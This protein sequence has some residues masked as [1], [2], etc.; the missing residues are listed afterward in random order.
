MSKRL[1]RIVALLL[2]PCLICDPRIAQASWVASNNAA[3]S[4]FSLVFQTQAVTEPILSFLKTFDKLHTIARNMAARPAVREL[5]K[6][7]QSSKFLKAHNNQTWK[8]WFWRI[9]GIGWM[10]AW[11]PAAHTVMEVLATG[12]TPDPV[13]FAYYLGLGTA[14]YLTGRYLSRTGRLTLSTFQSPL[15]ALLV[16]AAPLAFSLILGHE[17]YNA[18]AAG[19]GLP[20]LTLPHQN[21]QLS[22]QDLLASKR[23]LVFSD[24]ADAID[25]AVLKEARARKQ[26]YLRVTIRNQRDLDRLMT[27]LK[28]PYGGLA[29]ELIPGPLL[30]LIDSGGILLIDYNASDPKLVEIFNS[31]SDKRP[32]FGSHKV[33]PDHLT[34]I[35]VMKSADV[36]R[37]PVSFYSRF[38]HIVSME[39]PWAD[40]IAQ[41]KSI[42]PFK[43]SEGVSTADGGTTFL[44]PKDGFHRPVPEDPMEHIGKVGAEM[45]KLYGSP[46]FYQLL[47]GDLHL[48]KDGWISRGLGGS[49]FWAISRNQPLII[50]G[51]PWDNP[52]FIHFIR[53]MLLTGEVDI[54]GERL[55]LPEGF[56]IYRQDV[57]YSSGINQK[58]ILL[59]GEG[60]SEL[61]LTIVNRGT[62]DT[63]FAET[64][65]VDGLLLAHDGALRK[66]SNGGRIRITEAVDD[67]VW[68][69]IMHER[70]PIDVEVAPGVYIPEAY[71]SLRSDSLK[72]AIPEVKKETLAQAA[73]NKSMLVETNDPAFALER[74]SETFAGRHL[75]HY[76][77]T[78]ETSLTD[79]VAS[80]EVSGLNEGI[81]RAQVERKGILEALIKGDVVILEGLESNKDLARQLETAL[82]ETPYLFQYKEGAELN[83]LPGTLVVVAKVGPDLKV[84]AAH[85]TEIMA[86]DQTTAAILARE[87]PSKFR[88]E[89]YDKLLRLRKAIETIP[90][91]DQPGLYPPRPDFS[92]DRLRLLYR[93]DNWLEAFE[94][95]FI[96]LYADDPEKAAF[97][98]TQVRIAFDV[99]EPGRQPNSFV[100]HKLD[101]ALNSLIPHE[102]P[103]KHIWELTDAMSLDGL[104]KITIHQNFSHLDERP[105]RREVDRALIKGARGER[106]AFYRLRSG[107]TGDVSDAADIDMESRVGEPTWQEQVRTILRAFAITPVVMLKGLPGTGK[108]FI[109]S[110]IAPQLGFRENEVFGPITVGSDVKEADVVAR[111]ILKEGHTQLW[112]ETIA[113]WARHSEGG[114]LVVDEAN[115]ANPAFWNFMEGRFAAEPH[116]WI[117][118]QRVPLSQRHQILFTG[119]QESV[120][121]RK[122]QELIQRHA[123]T[124]HFSPFS[125]AF[126]RERINDDLGTQVAHREELKTLV[127]DLHRLFERMGTEITFSLRDVQELVARLNILIGPH[128]TLDQVVGTAWDLYQGNFDPEQRQALKHLINEKYGVVMA[129]WE[130]KR[131][132]EIRRV[133][134]PFFSEGQITLV[135]ATA[136]MVAAFDDLMTLREA[137]ISGQTILQG[138]RGMILEG[139]SG[140]GKDDPLELA[141]QARGLISDLDAPPGTPPHK[142]FYHRTARIDNNE[143]LLQVIDKAK[144]DGSLVI[145]SEANI[146]P[147][148]FMEGKLNDALTGN[149]APGF[150]FMMTV[151]S[152][153][154]SGRDKFS[155]ALL[156]RVIYRREQDYSEKELLEIVSDQARQLLSSGRISEEDVRHAVRAHLWIGETSAIPSLRPTPRELIR[157]V[158]LWQ[159]EQRTLTLSRAEELLIQ[160]YGP[161]YLDQVLKGQPLPDRTWLLRDFKPRSAVNNER[162]LERHA[163]ALV[164]S[165]KPARARLHGAYSKDGRSLKRAGAYQSGLDNSYTLSANAFEQGT[166][167][168]YILHE[169]G[170]GRRTRDLHAIQ[171][172]RELDPLYQDLEDLRQLNGLAA[173]LPASQMNTPA[174]DHLRFAQMVRTLN[175]DDLL[176]WMHTDEERL[177][178]RQMFA[179]LLVTHAKGLVTHEEADVFSEMV[180]ELLPM[181]PFQAALPFLQSAVEI[182]GAFSSVDL[183]E[184]H[185]FQQ[186]RMLTRLQTMRQAYTDIP[187]VTDLPPAPPAEEQQ[188][189]IRAAAEELKHMDL[190]PRAAAAAA[191]KPPPSRALSKEE[192]TAKKEALKKAIAESRKATRAE[193]LAELEQMEA[194]LDWSGGLLMERVNEINEAL[195]QERDQ[196][197][198]LLKMRQLNDPEIN[199][200]YKQM[201]E[202]LHKLKFEGNRKPSSSLGGIFDRLD[203]LLGSGHESGGGGLFKRSRK[204][205]GPRRHGARAHDANMT[206]DIVSADLVPRGIERSDLVL[207]AHE[208]VPR[209]DRMAAISRS[210]SRTLDAALADFVQ[211]QLLTDKVYG[212][213]GVLEIQKLLETRDPAVSHLRSGGRYEERKKEIVLMG[214]GKERDTS[215]NPMAQEILQH[216]LSLGFSFTVYTTSTHHYADGIRTLGNLKEAAGYGWSDEYN[217]REEI[218]KNLAERHKPKDSYIITSIQDLQAR[219]EA[220][221][222][223]GAFKSV[224]SGKKVEKPSQDADADMQFQ[225]DV[226]TVR[227]WLKARKL[228]DDDVHLRIN[229]EERSI[230]MDLYV[231]LQDPISGFE[232]LAGVKSLQGIKLY[233]DTNMDWHGVG[234]LKQITRLEIG[235][236]V[237]EHNFPRT[238]RAMLKL[239]WAELDNL[240]TLQ[241]A[242]CLIPIPF[243]LA[244]MPKLRRIEFGPPYDES[245]PASQLF[246]AEIFRILP[247]P[248]LIN[249]VPEDSPEPWTAARFSD[250]L[251]GSHLTEYGVGKEVTWLENMS[252]G[253]FWLRN[254]DTREGIVS[255]LEGRSEMD[256]ATLGVFPPL[257][258]A[259]YIDLTKSN[260]TDLTSLLRHENVR[261]IY[262]SE[263]Q[264]MKM[265]AEAITDFLWAHSN[266]EI[267]IDVISKAG[268]RIHR[269][270]M[271]DLAPDYRPTW[272][273]EAEPAE[274]PSRKGQA[275]VEAQLRQIRAILRAN[276][277]PE[278]SAEKGGDGISLSLLNGDV[279]FDLGVFREFPAL[280]YLDCDAA[281]ITDIASLTTLRQLKSLEIHNVTQSNLDFLSVLFPHLQSLHVAGAELQS[282]EPL[283]KAQ[284]LKTIGFSRTRLPSLAPLL[285]I[286]KLQKVSMDEYG[287]GPTDPFYVRDY[288]EVTDD[289]IL[290]FMRRHPN[291]HNLKF[292]VAGGR[293]I[294]LNADELAFDEQVRSVKI[295]L[296]RLNLPQKRLTV[297]DKKQW[298]ALDLH[299]A[300]NVKDF[301]ILKRFTR[302]AHLNIAG[303]NLSLLP[304]ATLPS[305]SMVVTD[306]GPDN[307]YIHFWA[308]FLNLKHLETIILISQNE[309]VLNG[310]AVFLRTNHVNRTRLRIMNER[311]LQ[312]FGQFDHEPGESQ[313][314][315][316]TPEQQEMAIRLFMKNRKIKHF[317]LHRNLS[318]IVLAIEGNSNFG[319]RELEQLAALHLTNLKEL[320]LQRTGIHSIEPIAK[321]TGLDK[322]DIS[323]TD[324]QSLEPVSGLIQLLEINISNTRISDLTPLENLPDLR[325]IWAR[326]IPSIR[327]IPLS[328][329]PRLQRLKLEGSGIGESHL[330]RLINERSTSQDL[331]VTFPSGKTTVYEPD[332][333]KESPA[334]E[335]TFEEQWQTTLHIV[336]TLGL[337]AARKKR[338]SLAS[339]GLIDLNLSG[340]QNLH[341]LD[342][343]EGLTELGALQLRNVNSIDITGLARFPRLHTLDLAGATTVLTDAGIQRLLAHH[344][345][346]ND[347]EITDTQGIRWR[348]SKELGVHK[349]QDESKTDGPGE[350]TLEQQKQ[351]IK[352][353]LNDH[354]IPK[355]YSLGFDGVED[356][357]VLNLWLPKDKLKVLDD[358]AALPL[359]RLHTFYLQTDGLQ[360]LPDFAKFIHLKKLI[361]TNNKS[362]VDV[363]A[364]QGLTLLEMLNLSHTSVSDL[365]PLRRLPHLS[366]LLI[367]YSRVTDFQPLENIVS[368][369]TLYA[370][371]LPRIEN[372]PLDRMPHLANLVLAESI[373]SQTWLD[374]TLK[375]LNLS[376]PLYVVDPDGTRRT[377]QP[378]T[379]QSPTAELTFEEQTDKAA[380][381]LKEMGLSPMRMYVDVA[382]K[383]FILNFAPDEG[384]FKDRATSISI[385]LERL[386]GMTNLDCLLL[387]GSNVKH[388]PFLKSLINLKELHLWDVPISDIQ[389]FA[390][391]PLLEDLQFYI[392]D[393]KMEE[394][395]RLFAAHPNHLNLKVMTNGKQFSWSDVPPEYRIPPL[396]KTYEE[397][398]EAAKQ[399]LTDL[400]LGMENLIQDEKRQLFALDLRMAPQS[401]FFSATLDVIKTFTRMAH[402]NI[403]N[404]SFPLE[405]LENLPYLSLLIYGY[406]TAKFTNLEKIPNL[407]IFGTNGNI[408]QYRDYL[409]EHHP[410]GCSI[411]VIAAEEAMKVFGIFGDFN[412]DI[413]IPG[414]S[415]T[416]ESAS[417]IF[418]DEFHIFSMKKTMGIADISNGDAAF[419]K[420]LLTSLVNPQTTLPAVRKRFEE[421]GQGPAFET[422]IHQV[423]PDMARYLKQPAQTSAPHHP[424]SDQ[425]ATG[426]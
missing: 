387:E 185:Q 41:I 22:I 92:L 260:V 256:D 318:A 128:W 121:G 54:Y 283:K 195:T 192:L 421:D 230:F 352:K 426:A 320:H 29:H 82:C 343:L 340:A 293:L 43:Q 114:L 73:E 3:K 347:L 216:L 268:S 60:T 241:I 259:D 317:E 365:R 288:A 50:T 257:S 155:T 126:L 164:R 39:L 402:L 265:G 341:N 391:L 264:Y 345:N 377:I 262:I 64:Y 37:H 211:R 243:V 238:N 312:E 346:R 141:A 154:F 131:V 411:Q 326:E 204:P 135:D 174:A 4:N 134:Q 129:D 396:G 378:R 269:F 319:D 139:P 389:M 168:E 40:P 111:R 360:V 309:V 231:L 310:M 404:F 146:L 415:A 2:I 295:L 159:E 169:E 289:Q 277:I 44:G 78:P 183:E 166:W 113:R 220:I 66:M 397:Q 76:P 162:M 370:K 170:H 71:R 287:A 6:N 13:T 249:I 59:P 108:S 175:F 240:E 224:M 58:R 266:P 86:D 362:L 93:Y 99:E 315:E 393:R 74:I 208:T 297:D 188:E 51:G 196:S 156:N 422:L 348:Y 357:L 19:F 116:V 79:L 95:V 302:L 201:M 354:G 217:S 158:G 181:N 358:L 300:E 281:R 296:T 263:A 392:S 104:K 28:I 303:I 237:M 226:A 187:K 311:A 239:P 61:P 375:A 388:L 18:L 406:P 14:S 157:L 294:T 401:A 103:D 376:R 414:I 244:K 337:D 331:H 72:H 336:K 356:D 98:R 384:G 127:L 83:N 418:A 16:L 323:N 97:M 235:L 46:M 228:P 349:I 410:Q 314:R 151:N 308:E 398:I 413:D 219:V 186:Y 330:E 383:R 117:N 149:A 408:D 165:A 150:V 306:T 355:N 101:R 214:L 327:H 373:I 334:R 85:R 34:I 301:D 152:T 191:H 221:Y 112:E 368:L 56:R 374:N 207:S 233:A 267:Q 423:A 9:A 225:E 124:V 15:A 223:Y 412:G 229:A 372:F 273:R 161:L 89:D 90:A 182:A 361:L 242:P 363:S 379:G 371:G 290:D 36:E 332:P 425:L 236:A 416:M 107:M 87:F 386:R 57:D 140:R 32:Y 17:G 136:R 333:R 102:P 193:V 25:A 10:Y 171:P 21:S 12:H 298:M 202:R 20:P 53:Q 381:L 367:S 409:E 80:I 227:E 284:N 205:I 194:D 120:T 324:V 47:F 23:T 272:E 38:Y 133:K 42:P 276:G 403:L 250:Y 180:A 68:H 176:A 77:I 153:D 278:D 424:G 399:L 105:I 279:T 190:E 35:G 184:E 218:E 335:L 285:A 178:L 26:P 130:Q 364:V 177:N 30:Q 400:G 395:Y 147:S 255:T 144:R 344:P 212:P 148:A 254:Q 339:G 417:R 199:R 69:W 7:Y 52:D 305:L 420:R 167:E 359:T 173:D 142:I 88:Q 143:E 215:F 163:D 247:Y 110:Q 145:V 62:Q 179:Y 248:S 342:A 274:E 45:V 65:V 245:D 213:E 380:S 313:A 172:N 338:Y 291:G 132:D 200:R 405:I 138:K 123:I 246:A 261:W 81:M 351:A 119:N 189:N 100:G 304:L 198:F 390:E 94:N 122:F 106:E 96:S 385:D 275:P 299:G 307:N 253:R 27:T 49:L 394:I 1:T 5:P 203:E 270:N 382:K 31:L 234:A 125:D 350:L 197:Q 33:A 280:V 258:F 321:F 222:T 328:L 160:I 8:D 316:L 63:L 252:S 369:T 11:I 286:P 206:Q 271:S 84:S 282:L 24:N 325:S 75:V 407:K 55:K 48:T 251:D 67:W 322:L 115:L 329:L 209:D 118:G 210:E 353:L 419:L 70:G 109:A 232:E 137:R 292:F 366:D 91:P